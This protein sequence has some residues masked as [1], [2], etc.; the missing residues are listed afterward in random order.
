MCP[1]I[2]AW[3]CISLVRTRT[4]QTQRQS[5]KITGSISSMPPRLSS[6]RL[7]L[8]LRIIAC[9]CLHRTCERRLHLHLHVR[10]H[11]LRTCK[12]GLIANLFF[13]TVVRSNGKV[14]MRLTAFSTNFQ[15]LSFN[16]LW[17]L[18]RSSQ[19]NRSL[20]LEKSQCLCYCI[21]LQTR[22]TEPTRNV[23][24]SRTVQSDATCHQDKEHILSQL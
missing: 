12:P 17:L 3:V 11:S 8:R 2:C 9:L 16:T 20:L 6:K 18:S 19:A 10:L 5:N 7:G 13:L 15:F 4:T 22:K 24:A 14:Q 1:F 21:K 23:D